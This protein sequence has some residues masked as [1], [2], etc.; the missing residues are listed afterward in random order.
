MLTF[1]TATLHKR[2]ITSVWRT[3]VLGAPASITTCDV[4]T[5]ADNVC[6]LLLQFRT[7][8]LHHLE[9]FFSIAAT[10]SIKTR[11]NKWYLYV[12]FQASLPLNHH[13]HGAS[14]IQ[15]KKAITPL[16]GEEMPW[17]LLRFFTR[18]LRVSNITVLST[19]CFFLGT[20]LYAVYF[21]FTSS[22]YTFLPSQSHIPAAC[23]KS[24]FPKPYT[25][26]PM[27]TYFLHSQF[28]RLYTFLITTSIW[29]QTVS[30]HDCL[31]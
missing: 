13:M 25:F 16:M 2:C 29:S 3:Q 19:S 15:C 30:S 8:I 18:H 17:F 26:V 21:Y 22:N 9:Q 1:T 7:D 5:A 27:P 12:E 10:Y 11:N 14:N 6:R 20:P 23:V 28:I 24:R 31:S 4:Q